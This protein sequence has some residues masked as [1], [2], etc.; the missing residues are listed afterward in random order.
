MSSQVVVLSGGI[1]GAKLALGLSRVLEPDQLT[2]IVNTGDDFTHLG[3][4]ICPDIDTTLYTLAGISNTELGW[5]RANESW[6]CLNAVEALGGESWFQLGDKDIALHLLRTQALAN[7][8][9]LAEITDTLRQRLGIKAKILPM[10]D[11]F[12]A[13]EVE[14]DEGLLAFQHYF[15]KRRCEPKVSAIRYNGACGAYPLLEIQDLLS[16]QDLRAII[17]APSNPYLS[18]DPILSV[19][20]MKDLLRN[21]NAPV[22]AVSPIIGGDAVKGP[23]AKIMGE[24]GIESSAHSVQVHYQSLIDGYVFDT[25]DTNMQ[26]EITIPS[27]CTNTLMKSLQ[28]R[29]QLAREVLE[30]ADTLAPTG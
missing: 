24:M 9:S 20:G 29:D 30:F 14:T 7:G 12:V 26:S 25:R 23:T 6:N 17:I 18:I 4:R 13:T 8:T 19:R 3:L 15:V 2:V 28:D 21:A 5:G 22:V 1:G 16:A 27:L 11:Q 10:S